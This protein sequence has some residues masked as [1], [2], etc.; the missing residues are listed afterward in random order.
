MTVAGGGDAP[1]GMRRDADEIE[2]GISEFARG[3]HGD[4]GLIVTA[5]G[6][7]IIHR[8]L[9]VALGTAHASSDLPFAPL[10]LDGGLITYEADTIDPYRRAAAYILRGLL[11]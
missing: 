10:C 1:G 3:S 5:S 4:R 8:Q 7:A 9:I 11:R 2:R 6:L